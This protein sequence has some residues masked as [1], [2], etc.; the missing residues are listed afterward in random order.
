MI[1]VA[2]EEGTQV[3][4]SLSDPF[5]VEVHRDELESLLDRVDLLFANE[6]EACGLEGGVGDWKSRN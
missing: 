4:L 1:A 6:Q 5:W 2:Q 3:A